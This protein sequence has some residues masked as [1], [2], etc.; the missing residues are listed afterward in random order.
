MIKKSV[1]EQLTFKNMISVDEAR[2]KEELNSSH[3]P[4]IYDRPFQTPG[5]NKIQFENYGL[6][7]QPFEKKL[8]QVS[9]DSFKEERIDE[10][11]EV[12]VRDSSSQFFSFKANVEAPQVSLN[13]VVM[14]L[15]RIY[16]GVT[17]YINP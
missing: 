17:E 1:N 4:L 11:F 8:I 6:M 3:L 9:L 5:K 15:G 14:N 7:L 12:M 13:R 10:H 16:A 2:T